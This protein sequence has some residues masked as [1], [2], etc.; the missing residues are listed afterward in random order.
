MFIL[1]FVLLSLV[2]QYVSFPCWIICPRI[3][4]ETLFLSWRVRNSANS[5][6][7]LWYWITPLKLH[8]LICKMG[9]ITYATGM[10]W[11]SNE[12]MLDKLKYTLLGFNV[13]VILCLAKRWSLSKILQFHWESSFLL[14]MSW[15]GTMST[16]LMWLTERHGGV[17]GLQSTRAKPN[18]INVINQWFLYFLI[19][20]IRFKSTKYYQSHI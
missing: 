7:V 10:L 4:K 2:Q 5:W 16:C 12:T 18:F 6:K 1:Q 15:E 19:S 9:I 17:S 8:I 14:T 13:V 3:S 11:L 20:M